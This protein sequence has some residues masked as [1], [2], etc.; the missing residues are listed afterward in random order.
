ML[1]PATPSWAG[2]GAGAEEPSLP[3]SQ[4]EVAMALYGGGITMGHMDLDA[5]C[6]A[7]IIMR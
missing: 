6:V 7:R 2:G 3:S 1:N 4:L 5:R